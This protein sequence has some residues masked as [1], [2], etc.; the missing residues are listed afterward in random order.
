MKSGADM[1]SS[2]VLNAVDILMKRLLK[3]VD[4]SISDSLNQLVIHWINLLTK[5]GLVSLF[6]ETQK[7]IFWTMCLLLF[8]MHL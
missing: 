7:E 2:P 5:P 8:F 4:E 1:L 6:H 3:R